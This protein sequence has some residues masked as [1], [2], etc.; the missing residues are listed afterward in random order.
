MLNGLQWHDRYPE[1]IS[2]AQALLSRFQECLLHL[3]VFDNDQDA[4]ACLKATLQKMGD[5]A[6]NAS[7]NGV[8]DFS[9]QLLK[10]MSA[11]L[12]TPPL[13]VNA[14]Q[15]LK[16]CLALFAWQIELINPQDGLLLLD[17]SEQC[18]LLDRFALVTG[19]ATLTGGI[20]PQNPSTVT[21]AQSGINVR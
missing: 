14:L 6:E 12:L 17:D 15:V 16:D 11:A 9:R 19:L 7:I 5:H 8:A 10:L 2:Q 13:P 4:L 20:T 1:F 18:A 21:R 3:E